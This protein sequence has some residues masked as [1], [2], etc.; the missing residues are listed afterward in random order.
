MPVRRGV[1]PRGCHRRAGG[2]EEGALYAIKVPFW[3]WSGLKERNAR[4][5]KRWERACETVQCFDQWLWLPAWARVMRVVVY[6]KCVRHLTAKNYPLDLF[7]TDDGY[8]EYSAIVTNKEVTGR[9]LRFFICG[10]GT[11][12]KAYDP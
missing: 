4:R 12:E 5:R 9:T 1:F 10:R 6:R 8:Y 7:D 3:R 2:E 11:H